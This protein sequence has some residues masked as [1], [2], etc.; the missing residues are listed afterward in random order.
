MKGLPQYLR[1]QSTEVFIQKN[2][3]FITMALNDEGHKRWVAKNKKT[4]PLVVK[5]GLVRTKG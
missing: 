5:R 2:Q 4:N 3:S 1:G